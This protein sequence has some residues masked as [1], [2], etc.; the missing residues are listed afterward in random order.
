M[1][2]PDGIAVYIKSVSRGNTFIEYVTLGA[3]KLPDAEAMECYIDVSDNEPYTVIVDFAKKLSRAARDGTKVPDMNILRWIDEEGV[4][5]GHFLDSRTLATRRTIEFIDRNHTTGGYSFANLQKADA[6]FSPEFG[7]I[8]VQVQPCAREPMSLQNSTSQPALPT[9]D[10]P[11][12]FV[13]RYRSTE[14]LQKLGVARSKG[15]V[16]DEYTATSRLG[17]QAISEPVAPPVHAKESRAQK[18]KR[19]KQERQVLALAESSRRSKEKAMPTKSTPKKLSNKKISAV[20]IFNTT[21]TPTEEDTRKRLELSSKINQP[22]VLDPLDKKSKLEAKVKQEEKGLSGSGDDFSVPRQGTTSS[23][24]TP[25][26]SHR[27]LPFKIPGFV[28]EPG[29]AKGNRRVSIN[30]T[31]D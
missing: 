30:L 23:I 4:G 3:Q 7:K 17:R 9:N 29:L 27:P 5:Q 14:Y 13:F 12:R 24:G 22:E 21:R 20:N 2:H 18:K 28:T 16:G 10:S 25:M 1:L 11:L 15:L 31:E 8:V 26:S 19:K 6:I